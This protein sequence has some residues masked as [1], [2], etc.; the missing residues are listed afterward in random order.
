MNDLELIRTFQP[1]IPSRE[2]ADR[3]ARVALDALRA[4]IDTPGPAPRR[5]PRRRFA[6]AL[7]GTVALLGIGAVLLDGS[8]STLSPA[9]ASALAIT[10]QAE[11]IELRIAD[12]SASAEEMTRQLNDAGI[13]GRVVLV[14][15]PSDYVGV[16][17]LTAQTASPSTC[18]PAPGQ[19]DPDSQ[20]NARLHDIQR[21]PNV[22]PKSL[23]IPV[24]QVREGTGGF[25]FVAGRPARQGEHP[26]DAGS[27]AAED[28][29]LET[30][31]PTDRSGP[32]TLPRC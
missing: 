3:A 31:E 4:R 27:T 7:A 32:T 26:I 13:R 6:L 20:G 2:A 18:A 19:P 8:N 9:P 5:L 11:W 29:L 22:K 1:E 10:R 25:L 23:R 17:L 30:L 14:P 21:I 28:R 12:E 24:A 16:W 15:V